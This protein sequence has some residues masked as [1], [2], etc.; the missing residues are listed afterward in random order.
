MVMRTK[1][2]PNGKFLTLRQAEQEYALP[3]HRLYRWVEGGQLPRLNR[4]ISG[5]S[6]YIKRA[7]L[8]AFLELNTD[9]ACRP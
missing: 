9:G 7:D 2:R 4:A 6:I 3:Y 5:C 1:S 8:D